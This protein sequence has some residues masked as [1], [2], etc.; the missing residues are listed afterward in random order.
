MFEELFPHWSTQQMEDLSIWA[1]ASARSNSDFEDIFMDLIS[2]ILINK[3]APRIQPGYI[4]TSVERALFKS[5]NSKNLGGE[6]SEGLHQALQEE[7]GDFDQ[8]DSKKKIK[9]F[10]KEIQEYL[11]PSTRKLIQA[12]SA[13]IEETER[14]PEKYDKKKFQLAIRKNLERLGVVVTSQN[15]RQL[16]KRLRESIMNNAPN[17]R[18]TLSYIPYEKV[19]VEEQLYKIILRAMEISDDTLERENA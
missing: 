4:R 2:A 3:A 14:S 12:I 10:I 15:M 11:T 19:N 6:L 5:K 9:L 13:A 1:K 18:D 17:A 8:P 16:T 7:F